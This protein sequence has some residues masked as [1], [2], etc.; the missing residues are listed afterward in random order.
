MGKNV[1]RDLLSLPYTW[2]LS[3]GLY[4]CSPLLVNKVLMFSRMME[5]SSTLSKAMNTT[6]VRYSLSVPKES[7]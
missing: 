7:L 5:L 6:L 1:S 4:L 2:R 3:P